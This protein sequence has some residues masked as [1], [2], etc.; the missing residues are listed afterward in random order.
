[1]LRSRQTL[2]RRIVLLADQSNAYNG[3]N[4]ADA[5]AKIPH[6]LVYPDS[7]MDRVAFVTAHCP[8]DLNDVVLSLGIRQFSMRYG[9]T[10]RER[11]PRK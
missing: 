1:M 2:E 10:W 4:Y 9:T 5:I 3:V 6:L 8:G 7:R 11:T